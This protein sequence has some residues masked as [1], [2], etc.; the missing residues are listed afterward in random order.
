M[1]PDDPLPD[2]SNIESQPLL[3]ARQRRELVRILAEE[4]PQAL[5]AWIEAE[6]KDDPRIRERVEAH[7]EGLERKARRRKR[8]IEERFE[9][10]EEQVRETW[11]TQAEQAQAR[12]QKL[13]Q[14]IQ[15]LDPTDRDRLAEHARG[16]D[17][18]LTPEEAEPTLWERFRG[19]LYRV[20]IVVVD[21]FARLWAWITGTRREDEGPVID[22]GDVQVDLPELTKTN[23]GVVARVKRRADDRSIRERMRDWW[24]RLRGREDYTT[25]VEDLM[26]RE[27]EQA[28]QEVEAEVA[29]ERERLE[30]RIEEIETE[31][32]EAEREQTKRLRE[33]EEQREE[34]LAEV[35]E[36]VRHE[37]LE[38]VRRELEGELTD[39]GLVGE[40]GRPTAALLERFSSLLYEEVHRALPRGGRARPGAFVGG[41][42][43]YEKGPL[44]SLNE[45]GAAAL[46]DSIVRA[47]QN[48]P[49]SDH[50]YDRDL[51]VRR[52]VKSTRTHVV[53][54]FDRSGSMEEKGRFEAAKR[55]C[56]VMY[57]AVRDHDPRHLVDIVSMSTHVDQVGLDETWNAELGGFTNHAGA[58]DLSREILASS[59]ADRRLVYLVTDGLPEAYYDEGGD[60]VV[61]EPSVC[62]PPTIEAA[63]RLGELENTRLTMLQ[64][65]TEDE[66]YLDAAEQIAHAAG[67]RM[68]GLEPADLTEEVVLDF[69]AAVESRGQRT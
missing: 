14:Q 41:E 43:T 56:L 47:R 1:S 16:M 13:V 28:Q 35:D 6:A 64:L 31:R 33:L 68:Q 4:G 5:E 26:R 12:E 40:D 65:E 50:I 61:D 60:L 45:R 59:P 9:E 51:I 36:Q 29:E 52:E 27:L 37:P 67:G 15:T 17:P 3:S 8:R 30:E 2:C 19:W 49:T 42:G 20:W 44:R 46:A 57:Q 54:V 23:P 53:L 48:H 24:N 38:Q 63:R 55:V 18:L 22:L 34:E 21:A 10:E 39:A 69:E 7:R 58:L 62:L 32:K 25:T 11:G 66:L